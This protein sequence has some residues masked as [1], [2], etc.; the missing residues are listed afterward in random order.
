VT[1]LSPASHALE[2]RRVGN[3][4]PSRVA[5]NFFWLGRYAERAEAVAR[6]LRSAL[7]RL[8]IEREGG[9]SPV[10]RPMLDTLRQQGQLSKDKA[11]SKE[12]EKL[13]AELLAAIFDEKRP[14]SLSSVVG[15]LQQI[16]LLL[17]DR[18]SSDT[19]RLVVQLINQFSG[20]RSDSLLMSGEPLAIL[21][22]VILSLAALE[23]LAMENMTRAQG[24]RFLDMGHR[25][26]RSVYLCTLLSLALRSPVAENPSLL[27]ALLEIADSSLTYRSRYTLLPRIA[28]VYDLL[29]L[30]DTNPRSLIF[31]LSQLAQ[32]F[33][34]LPREK[35]AALPSPG[36]RILIESLSQLRLTDPMELGVAGPSWE[37]TKVAEVIGFIAGAMPR[38]SDAI[39]VSH[40]SH[41]AV[42]RAGARNVIVPAVAYRQSL[43]GVGA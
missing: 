5:D 14:G 25:L 38:L 17:R 10:L 37:D 11:E 9:A 39:A 24:W 43:N 13:E 27:E 18:L 34:F 36:Q 32:H 23:G 29:L 31:Q 26:E 41:S 15:R 12:S 30:D 40:F 19:W 4:L 3:N 28:A 1:L 22:Q 6:L 33:E 16:T 8:S 42:T 21:N 7:L 2:L 20:P 35:V